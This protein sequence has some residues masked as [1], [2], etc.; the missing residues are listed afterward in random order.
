MSSIRLVNSTTLQVPF[1]NCSPTSTSNSDMILRRPGRLASP[2]SCG[3]HTDGLGRL[4]AYHCYRDRDRNLRSDVGQP[5]R[6]RFRTMLRHHVVV[7]RPHHCSSERYR[8]LLSS[9]SSVLAAPPGISTQ[10]VNVEEASYFFRYS[11]ADPV[12]CENNSV[13]TSRIKPSSLNHFEVVLTSLLSPEGVVA[14]GCTP[15]NL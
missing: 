4:Y 6:R 1:T 9:P 13:S 2:T 5:I 15:F 12:S 14:I 11:T 8:P 7:Q 3:R 10:L